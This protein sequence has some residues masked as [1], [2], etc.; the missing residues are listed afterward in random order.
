[1]CFRH[2]SGFLLFCLLFLLVVKNPPTDAGDARH[3]FYPWSKRR[4]TTSVFLT[5]KYHGQRRLVGYSPWG[6]K[7]SDMTEQLTLSQKQKCVIFVYILRL[8]LGVFYLS[9]ELLIIYS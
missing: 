3:G 2:D 8:I 4:Q 9:K 1:M 6:L 7:E 5:E